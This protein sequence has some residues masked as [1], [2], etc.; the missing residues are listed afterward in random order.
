MVLDSADV[1]SKRTVSWFEVWSSKGLVGGSESEHPPQKNKARR[2]SPVRYRLYGGYCKLEFVPCISY[3]YFFNLHSVKHGARIA[4]QPPLRLYDLLNSKEFC[5]RG[6]YICS[7]TYRVILISHCQA[8]FCPRPNHQGEDT[9][10]IFITRRVIIGVPIIDVLD[11]IRILITSMF[12]HHDHCGIIG[13]AR[14]PLN[15]TPQK[16]HTMISTVKIF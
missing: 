2:L 5:Y 6:H 16:A 8:R 12:R 11:G 7:V 10:R 14:Y 3:L 4:V 1:N 13:H 9:A 15:F